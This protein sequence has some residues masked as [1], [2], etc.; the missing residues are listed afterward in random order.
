MKKLLFTAL[1]LFLP[2]GVDAVSSTVTA[3][4]W[5]LNQSAVVTVTSPS[6]LDDQVTIQY[7]ATNASFDLT[8]QVTDNESDSIYYTITPSVWSVSSDNWWPHST[9]STYS[10]T[11][12]YL[13]PATASTSETITI[14][15]DDWSSVTTKTVQLYIY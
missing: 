4:V 13:A 15:I 8:F 3:V 11:I 6:V 1:A 5:N 2:F 9:S 14:T 7:I 12:T 10:K